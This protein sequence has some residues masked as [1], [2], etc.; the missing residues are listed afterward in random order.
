MLVT[1]DRYS[2][3]RALHKKLVRE[4]IIDDRLPPVA[5][6]AEWCIVLEVLD[7]V[8]LTRDARETVETR[9]TITG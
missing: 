8:R 5:L 6:T 7:R 3:P 9:F 1:N 4:H 2:T